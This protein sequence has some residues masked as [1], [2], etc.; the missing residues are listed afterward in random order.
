[1]FRPS[2]CCFLWLGFLLL[3]PRSLQLSPKMLQRHL[4]RR[5]RRTWPGGWRARS[6]STRGSCSSAPS[7]W[8]APVQGLG[9]RRR[10]RRRGPASTLRNCCGASVPWKLSVQ[11]IRT[12]KPNK[13]GPIDLLDVFCYRDIYVMYRQAFGSILGAMTLIHAIPTVQCSTD[14]CSAVRWGAVIPAMDLFVPSSGGG[15]AAAAYKGLKGATRHIRLEAARR[16][17]LGDT[18]EWHGRRRIPFIRLIVR[19]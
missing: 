15:G 13:Q 16:G 6:A 3:Q 5:V 11:S 17:K 19:S 8:R 9:W 14:H 10:M 12:G 4:W 7:P 1:M 18:K 2:Y